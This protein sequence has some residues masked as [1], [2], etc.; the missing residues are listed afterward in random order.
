MAAAGS[1]YIIFFSS[2]QE[3]QARAG[4]DGW[5]M[6][7]RDDMGF[8]TEDQAWPKERERLS[9]IAEQKL[10]ALRLGGIDNEALELTYTA[11]LLLEAPDY[12]LEEERLW[13]IEFFTQKI[14]DY[15]ADDNQ[16]LLRLSQLQEIV[17]RP[18]AAPAEDR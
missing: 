14:Y 12:D 13:C 6:L 7:L 3:T 4:F 10:D 18:A 15:V 5:V 2:K 11:H 17:L 8:D 1:A 16:L 9:A